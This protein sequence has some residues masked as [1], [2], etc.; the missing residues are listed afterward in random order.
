MIF[1][2]SDETRNKLIDEYRLTWS[3]FFEATKPFLCIIWKKDPITGRQMFPKREDYTEEDLEKNA[4]DNI[5]EYLER[6]SNLGEINNNLREYYKITEE[7]MLL[8]I[9]YNVYSLDNESNIKIRNEWIRKIEKYLRNKAKEPKFTKTLEIGNVELEVS[10]L[11]VPYLKEKLKLKKKEAERYL[12]LLKENFIINYHGI[13][14]REFDDP[15]ASSEKFIDRDDK[16]EIYAQVADMIKKDSLEKI[17]KTYLMKKLG[18]SYNA[19]SMLTDTLVKRRFLEES[20]KA[21]T[22]KVI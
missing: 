3:E 2:C 17:S 20:K 19:V 12:N 10:E 18:F 1:N 16:E 21:G 9:G 7:E 8:I 14:R 5:E 13:R 15:S 11:S 22:F 4:R 6:Y